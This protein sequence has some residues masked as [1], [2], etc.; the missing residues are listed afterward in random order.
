[1]VPSRPTLSIRNDCS[2]LRGNKLR[3]TR[4]PNILKRLA[5]DEVVNSLKSE[6]GNRHNVKLALNTDMQP[7]LWGSLISP[8]LRVDSR[9]DLELRPHAMLR[10]R[11]PPPCRLSSCGLLT[12]ACLIAFFDQFAPRFVRPL[13]V[14]HVRQRRLPQPRGSQATE[15]MALNRPETPKESYGEPSL[16]AANPASRIG[17]RWRPIILI[18]VQSRHRWQVLGRVDHKWFALPSFSSPISD[19]VSPSPVAVFPWDFRTS[20]RVRPIGL[21]TLGHRPLFLAP[22]PG[23]ARR[24]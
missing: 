11:S 18:L 4:G 22:T 1:M 7:R 6:R 2:N 9:A 12:R 16:L 10:R 3:N 17:L 19:E 24:T 21:P 14:I 8:A 15:T 13:V 20:R 5:L 23:A